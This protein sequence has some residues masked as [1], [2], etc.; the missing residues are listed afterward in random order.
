MT[1][2]PETISKGRKIAAWIMVGL[3]T[4]LLLFSGTMKLIG[5]P[6]V[7][8]TFSKYGLD[9]KMTLIG[10]GELATAILFFIP[11]TSSLGVL[12]FSAYIGGA[13][14]THMEHDEP[15]MVAALILIF[16][17]F[18]NWLRNPE[19]FYSLRKK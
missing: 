15:Y 7:A 11:R 17:W 3:S 18:A 10:I 4:A 1:N 8:A 9:G 5:A 16:G 12:L 19:M 13:I 6:E 2:Q 14:A